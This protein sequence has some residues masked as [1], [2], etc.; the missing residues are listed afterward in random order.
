[1]VVQI[2]NNLPPMQK[3]WVRSLG[4]E[5]PLEKGMATHSSILAWKISWTEELGRLQSMR[6]QRVGHDWATN[7]HTHTNVMAL[8]GGALG[9]W[10]DHDGGTLELAPLWKRP[11][12]VVLPS[13][14]CEHIARKRPSATQKTTLTRT[15][16]CQHPHV[17]LQPLE[18][19][20]I[21]LLFISHPVYDILL[22]WIRPPAIGLY[23]KW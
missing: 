2:V 17:R 15:W 10:S 8:G 11:Q 13:L 23:K 3:N 6:S 1:M 9:R 22:L 18:L 20:E 16:P 5:D 4:Q 14:P 19:W 21:H 7:T 12:G